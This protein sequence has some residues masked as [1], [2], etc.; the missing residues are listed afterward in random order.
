LQ[1]NNIHTAAQVLGQ[2][3]K[4]LRIKQKLTQ[5]EL[6]DLIGADRQYVWK[7]ENGKTNMRLS[8]LDKIIEA[9]NCKHEDFL[10]TNANP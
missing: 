4:Q 3:I 7:L 10:N 8:S 1:K 5:Q 6:G 2:R 9:L